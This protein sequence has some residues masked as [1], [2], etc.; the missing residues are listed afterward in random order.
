M[1]FGLLKSELTGGE[2]HFYTSQPVG[3][4]FIHNVGEV[5]N[6]GED[7]ICAA[8]A[9]CTFLNWRFPDK[10]WDPWELFKSAG[11]TSNGISFKEILSYLRKKG[12]I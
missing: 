10:Y 3:N 11:G 1:N 9:V 7:P 4:K 12:I 8:C 5:I 2:K 6:Q